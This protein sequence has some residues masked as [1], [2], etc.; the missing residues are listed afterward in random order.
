MKK[1]KQK[2]EVSKPKADI[3]NVRIMSMM[4]NLFSK[5]SK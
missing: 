1:A 5:N 2:K 3:S 4:G